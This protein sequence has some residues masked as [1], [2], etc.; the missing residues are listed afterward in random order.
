MIIIRHLKSVPYREQIDS[1][2]IAI[3]NNSSDQYAIELDQID[4]SRGVR[5]PGLPVYIAKDREELR[6]KLAQRSY[7]K[8]G[9]GYVLVTEIPDEVFSSGKAVIGKNK[10]FANQTGKQQYVRMEYREGSFYLPE[11]EERYIDVDLIGSFDKITKELKSTSGEYY[12]SRV[13]PRETYE[14]EVFRYIDDENLVE[15]KLEDLPSEN[16]E[17]GYQ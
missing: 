13:P 8:N 12:L 15:V 6:E 11:G 16:L 2:G 5:V 1:L 14:L 9:D 4:S 17:L 3:T 7:Y 10:A